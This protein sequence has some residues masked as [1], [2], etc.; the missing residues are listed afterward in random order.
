MSRVPAA[1]DR[2]SCLA[3]L[4][5]VATTAAVAGR[6]AVAANPAA[7]NSAVGSPTAGNAPPA[8]EALDAGW[9]EATCLVADGA[10]FGAFAEQV[11]GWQL[12]P[13]QRVDRSLAAFMGLPVDSVRDARQWRVSDGSGRAA[14]LR[15]VELPGLPRLRFADG[16]PPPVAPAWFAGGIFSLMTRSNSLRERVLRARELGWGVVAEPVELAFG[17]VQLANVIL[18][19]PQGVNVA[20]YERLA[21]RLPDDP[22]LRRLRRPFNSMQVVADLPLAR[23]FYVEGLGFAVVGEGQFR[24]EPG[25]PNNFGI[26]AEL[27]A[28][29]A[30]D[31]LIVAPRAGG[32]TQVEIV[33]FRGLPAGRRAAAGPA[34][35]G[36]HA[37][38]F[39]VRQVARVRE[40]LIAAGWPLDTIIT[41]V[42][43]GGTK[44]QQALAVTTP[45]GARLEF[46][47][48]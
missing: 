35:P 45:E 20:I 9:S 15:I 24:W 44:A 29:A 30:L 47:E 16:L 36:I 28:G 21:P 7:G 34:Q 4:S 19:G 26:P 12:D 10:A 38:R 40:R 3:A 6:M 25:K 39:P 22:D 46:I 5:A 37:L 33:Q 8:D 18:L 23:N 14:A 43:F 48:A 13:P 32:P 42:V 27:A 17:N 2:R 31:Y 11:A 1:I 41:E